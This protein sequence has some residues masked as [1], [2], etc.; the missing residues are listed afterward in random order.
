MKR[1]EFITGLGSAAAW[2]V[3]ARTQE[4]AMPVIGYLSSLTRTIDVI[5]RGAFQK[6]LNEM[7]L[8]LGRKSKR[9]LASTC[10]RVG[11]TAGSRD[12]RNGWPSCSA[13]R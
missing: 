10:G 13:G 9:S 6:G 11:P 7:G 8:S 3:M 1:R 2:P 4:P 12:C 5:N